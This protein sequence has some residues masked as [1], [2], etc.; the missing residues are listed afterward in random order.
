MHYRIYRSGFGQMGDQIVAVISAK[1]AEDY[2][3]LSTENNKVLGEEGRKKFQ[4]IL[5]L[6]SDYRNIEGKMRPDLA[7][8]PNTESQP[9]VKD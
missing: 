7:F 9:V 6:V 5:D 3:R 1:D 8:T 4:E 2:A